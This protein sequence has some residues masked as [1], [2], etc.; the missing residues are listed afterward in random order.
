MASLPAQVVYTSVPGPTGSH[1][2]SHGHVQHAQNH[3]YG[4][5]S[6]SSLPQQERL[7]SIRDLDF[8]YYSQPQTPG[9]ASN[10]ISAQANQPPHPHQHAPPP[11]PQATSAAVSGVQRA[12]Q[13]PPQHHSYGQITQPQP[14]SQHISE[15]PALAH[16]QIPPSGTTVSAAG[17]RGRAWGALPHHSQSPA[18]PHSAGSSNFGSGTMGAPPAPPEYQHHLSPPPGS[19]GMGAGGGIHSHGAVMSGQGTQTSLKRPR[20]ESLAAVGAS[21]GSSAEAGGGLVGGGSNVSVSPAAAASGR[22]PHVSATVPL[23]IFKPI[24]TTIS[25]TIHTHCPDCLFS[26]R[27]INLCLLCLYSLPFYYRTR[28]NKLFSFAVGWHFARLSPCILLALRHI[29]I[30]HLMCIP[31]MD[32]LPP[33]RTHRC[34]CPF[35]QGLLE[36][37]CQLIRPCPL[38][39]H[40][41]ITRI[42]ISLP[43]PNHTNMP[44]ISR[45][46]YNKL[47]LRHTRRVGRPRFLRA[48]MV[49]PRPLRRS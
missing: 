10:S 31:R 22:S 9:P 13:Q 20:S 6:I 18:P 7:P 1:P 21:A 37:R 12:R 34:R 24:Y 36:P 26:L 4:H 47:R 46:T 45:I 48:S 2:V 35:L 14:Q 15:S 30:L 27:A 17:V 5:A 16:G 25:N 39:F 11:P 3:A 44:R 43:Q 42:N 32:L 28:A 19:A 41:L 38:R 29:H 33:L 49:R 40:I 23:R 8:Q